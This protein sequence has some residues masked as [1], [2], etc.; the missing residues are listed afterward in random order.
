MACHM[1]RQP[2]TVKKFD[3]RHCGLWL[4]L[5]VCYFS[6]APA[7]IFADVGS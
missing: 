7:R 4:G 3:G 1:K 6:V 5:R 2:M